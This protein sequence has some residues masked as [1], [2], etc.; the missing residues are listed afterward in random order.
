M[1]K[2][3]PE[4][5][6]TPPG[7]NVRIETGMESNRLSFYSWLVPRQSLYLS[8]SWLLSYKENVGLSIAGDLFLC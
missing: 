4:A 3:T 1:N 5:G 2:T 8:R 6:P 7:D